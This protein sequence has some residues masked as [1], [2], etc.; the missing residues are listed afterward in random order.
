MSSQRGRRLAATVALVAVVVLAGCGGLG[1]SGSSPAADGGDTNP[2]NETAGNG[3]GRTSG[4][5][6]SLSDALA[7]DSG[8][9]DSYTATINTHIAGEEAA[10]IENRTLRVGADG[11][12]RSET[13]RRAISD[14]ETV[15]LTDGYTTG[16]VTFLQHSMAG[17]N[18]TSYERVRAD[19]PG[20]A[21]GTPALAEQFEFAHEQLADRRHRFTVNSTDQITGTAFGD[22]TVENVSVVVVVEDGIITS[23]AYELTVSTADGPVEYDT[24]RT[25]SAR[26]ETTVTEPDWLSQA[27]S[28][29]TPVSG[30]E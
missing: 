15:A 3:D 21:T 28:R 22:S 14:N 5:V 12:V 26:G 19:E 29:T 9:T 27:K 20:T 13:R 7:S 2:G 24:D 25:V 11:T 30:E 8:A 6:E 17:I 10:V 18:A 16:D 23:L 1:G 4:P